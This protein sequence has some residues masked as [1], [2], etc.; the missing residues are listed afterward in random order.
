MSHFKAQTS[1]EGKP[2]WWT[3]VAYAI[4]LPLYGLVKYLPSPFGDPLR[5][6][7]NWLFGMRAGWGWIREGVTI[8]TPWRVRLGHG[9]SLNEGVQ[10]I[11][12]GIITIGNHVRVAPRAVIVATNHRF[13]DPHQLIKNQGFDNANT[14]IGDDVWIGAHAMVLTGVTVGRGAVVA[15]GAVVTQDVAD[16]AIVGGVP[17]RIIGQ[18]GGGPTS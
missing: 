7:V 3:C 14:T 9:W 18:R 17:A 2:S 1:F 15:A 8:Y 10:L 16:Y 13:T 11:P 4:Y 5:W 6:L 12:G